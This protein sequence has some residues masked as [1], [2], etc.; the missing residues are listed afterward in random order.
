MKST[1]VVIAALAAAAAFGLMGCSQS[2]VAPDLAHLQPGTQ[3]NT[4]QTNDPSSDPN[5]TGPLVGSITIDG[6]NPGQV[7]AGRWSLIIPKKALKM[8]AHIVLI[9]P[10]PDQLNVSFEITPP[11]ANDFQQPVTLVADLSRDANVDVLGKQLFWLQGTD[12]L[13]AHPSIAS[14]AT[15]SIQTNAKRLEACMIGDKGVKTYGN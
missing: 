5:G 10:D 6:G 15:R 4:Q 11:E 14:A 12:W 9:Q 3:P 1:R 2:P 13:P 8:K 7:K